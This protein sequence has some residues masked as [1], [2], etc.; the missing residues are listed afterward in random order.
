MDSGSVYT[1]FENEGIES[2]T[3]S[4]E[5]DEQLNLFE[6]RAHKNVLLTE[7]LVEIIYTISKEAVSEITVEYLKSR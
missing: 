4:S 6:A 2:F 7:F 1:A 5:V 3:G